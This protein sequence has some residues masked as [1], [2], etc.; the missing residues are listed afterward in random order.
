M[1]YELIDAFLK[2]MT[3]EELEYIDNELWDLLDSSKEN[4]ND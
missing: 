4:K 3:K 2:D 1:R